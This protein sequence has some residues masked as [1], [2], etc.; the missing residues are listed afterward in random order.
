M[1]PGIRWLAG[2]IAALLC[3]GG[4]FAQYAQKPQP[5]TPETRPAAAP[6]EPR[7]PAPARA[8]RPSRRP[9]DGKPA[10]DDPEC[11]FTGKR[12]V[13]SLA[14]DDVDT[15]QKFVRFYEMFSCPAGHLRDAF[16]CAVAGGAP[17]PGKPLSDRVDQCWD[18]PP[19]PAK[20][21]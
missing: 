3:A 9:A 17:A 21:R 10:A 20:N 13:N 6:Q 2:F 16:R 1:N 7:R 18:K 11:A 5:T 4:T 8:E 19:A 12:I 15:A 14:R